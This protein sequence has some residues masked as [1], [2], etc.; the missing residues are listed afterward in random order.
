MVAKA[1]EFVWSKMSVKMKA[2]A[3]FQANR[4]AILSQR[5]I[6]NPDRKRLKPDR[7]EFK[8]DVKGN[9]ISFIFEE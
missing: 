9:A 1:K 8:K 2:S 6:E 4:E 5:N 3:V 7:P